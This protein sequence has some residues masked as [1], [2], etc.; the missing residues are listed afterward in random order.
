MRRDYLQTIDAAEPM[1]VATDE[2]VGPYTAAL[3]CLLGG[4]GL[5]A[6]ILAA[7]FA[8]GWYTVG[9]YTALLA[10][11]AFTGLLAVWWTLRQRTDVELELWRG[12][13]A[14][15]R[16]E[17]LEGHLAQAIQQRDA[18]NDAARAWRDQ[19][20][21]LDRER[22][23]RQAPTFVAPTSPPDDPVRRDAWQLVVRRYRRNEP[24]SRRYMAGLK[25]DAARYNAA[26]ALLRE[27]GFFVGQQW[28]TMSE[29]EAM[30]MFGGKP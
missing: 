11:L 24:V 13:R 30:Q 9:M 18:A 3:N 7:S 20:E 6:I 1:P 23:Q 15:A 5:A 14:Q 8:F 2:Y 29:T 26:C 12:R 17:E 19:A 4:A 16:L 27:R 10:G 28:R 21:I 25:W 22:K